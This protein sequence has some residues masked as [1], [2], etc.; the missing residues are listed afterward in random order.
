MTFLS[1]L[2]VAVL[3]IIIL[4]I[5]VLLHENGMWKTLENCAQK[6]LDS[7]KQFGKIELEKGHIVFI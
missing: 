1:E 7:R 2:P 6:R 5:I 4:S 3:R